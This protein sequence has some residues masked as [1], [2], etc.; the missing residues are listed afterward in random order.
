MQGQSCGERIAAQGTGT[1]SL[2]F[3]ASRSQIWRKL[4]RATRN[5]ELAS[6][7]KPVSFSEIPIYTD[8]FL[9]RSSIEFADVQKFLP[10]L[11]PPRLIHV[12]HGHGRPTRRRQADNLRAQVVKMLPP[13]LVPWV[14]NSDRLSSLDVNSA[15]I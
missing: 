4:L 15:E 12:E 13:S 5:S 14:E 2:A 9:D 10:Q 7:D 1:N 8:R 6:G 3:F 11:E